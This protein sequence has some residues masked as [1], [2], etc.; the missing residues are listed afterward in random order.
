MKVPDSV[1]PP[2]ADRTLA[3]RRYKESVIRGWDLKA[4]AVAMGKQ[5]EEEEILCCV[6]DNLEGDTPLDSYV[7]G[8]SKWLYDQKVAISKSNGKGYPDRLKDALLL[9]ASQAPLSYLLSI[10]KVHHYHRIDVKSCENIFCW[11]DRKTPLE[12]A[13]AARKAGF[14][15]EM[16]EEHFVQHLTDKLEKSYPP[17][18]SFAD[19][20]RQFCIN[21]TQPTTSAETTHSHPEEASRVC[22]NCTM[23]D[24]DMP[25]CPGPEFN[26]HN[27]SMY[28]RRAFALNRKLIEPKE[29]VPPL[30]SLPPAPPPRPRLKAPKVHPTVSNR[31]ANK[32][33]RRADPD[34]FPASLSDLVEKMTEDQTIQLIHG[35]HKIIPRLDDG[36]R[37]HCDRKAQKGRV[38][39]E[40]MRD[41][42]EAAM[43]GLT[44]RKEPQ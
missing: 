30:S 12:I 14:V 21:P 34:H 6:R 33:L 10:H 7:K 28:N 42:E 43:R 13:E 1:C 17:D 18:A 35:E 22:Y 9:R 2:G 26:K 38:F 15:P 41:L 44:M 36:E 31:K 24:H 20:T 32:Q 37:R 11:V 5:L 29:K 19:P 27:R 8:I 39:P 40:Q 4:M 25:D 16:T 23:T 3:I